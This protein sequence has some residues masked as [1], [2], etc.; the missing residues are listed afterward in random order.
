M[1]VLN[2]SQT[3]VGYPEH[4]RS[5]SRVVGVSHMSTFAAM[6]FAEE[7]GI[8]N[9]W[10]MADG[11]LS[12]LENVRRGAPT[13]V[14]LSAMLA[15]RRVAMT[16]GVTSGT[17]WFAA[18]GGTAPVAGQSLPAWA[19]SAK[20]PWVEVIDN[21]TCYWGGLSDAQ[22]ARLLTWFLCQH[23]MEADFKKVKIQPRT[24]ARL[25]AGL[26]DH[27][28]TRNLQLVRGDRKLCDL[29]AG[30]HGS[31]I[32]EHATRPLPT[33]AAI[34]LRLTIDFG[35]LSCE[36]L[37]DRCPLVDETGKLMPGR[38]SGLWGRA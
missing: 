4:T 22:A 35:E 23:P 27:G 2:W 7:L 8:R 6:R 36:D 20:Q 12:Q 30:V 19:E 34:G 14:T 15:D 13:A 16:E 5:G 18:A 9:G 32:L 11:A 38:P 33:Q 29:W 25:K 21:E 31:C 28:W 10:L 17:L 37:A 3:V 24:F 26:F 1:A